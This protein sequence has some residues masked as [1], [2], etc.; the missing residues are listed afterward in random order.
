M[1][2]DV[3]GFAKE[4]VQKA[5]VNGMVHEAVVFTVIANIQQHCL[6]LEKQ[7]AAE[8]IE[9]AKLKDKLE[10]TEGKD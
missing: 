7:L 1:N 6:K 9:N 5:S 10:S 2:R 4:R 3:I 8:K